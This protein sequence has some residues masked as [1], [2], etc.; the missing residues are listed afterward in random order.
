MGGVAAGVAGGVIGGMI[1]GEAFEDMGDM[2]MDFD[3]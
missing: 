1:L 3:F 2:D